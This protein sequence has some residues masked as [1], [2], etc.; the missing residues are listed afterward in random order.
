MKNLSILMKKASGISFDLDETLMSL[1]NAI[2][3]NEIAKHTK[4]ISE[5]IKYVRKLKSEINNI[6]IHY[7]NEK[8]TKEEIDN[9]TKSVI[10]TFDSSPQAIY[11][12]EDTHNENFFIRL[13]IP[14]IRVAI[15]KEIIK[16]ASSKN[17][18]IEFPKLWTDII[19]NQGLLNGEFDDF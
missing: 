12:Y 8:V 13:K 5:L 1:S 16:Q 19:S 18:D 15:C 11:W 17:D 4:E 9:A 14:A 10:K 3:T 2:E 6:H 7:L